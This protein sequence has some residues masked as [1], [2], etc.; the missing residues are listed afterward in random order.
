MSSPPTHTTTYANSSVRLAVAVRRMNSAE[1]MASVIAAKDTAK[2]AGLTAK[3]TESL[4][5]AFDAAKDR[6]RRIARAEQQASASTS[7]KAP[8]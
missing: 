8:T 1:T 3:D 5:V 7:L 6:I 2:N 4:R